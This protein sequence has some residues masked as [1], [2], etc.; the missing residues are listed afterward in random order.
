[1]SLPTKSAPITTADEGFPIAISLGEDVSSF[2]VYQLILKDPAGA[3][4]TVAC[5]ADPNDP[6]GM[7][8]NLI[9]TTFDSVGTWIAQPRLEGAGSTPIKY[10][11]EFE[12]LIL[13]PL[14]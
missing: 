10:G 14:S 9:S 12:I 1:M 7:L 2:I 4:K 6:C 3:V 13:D 8:L 5:V 11:A